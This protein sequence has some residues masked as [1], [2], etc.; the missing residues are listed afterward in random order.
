MTNQEP[1]PNL[2][3]NQPALRRSRGTE[4]IVVGGIFAAVTVTVLLLTGTVPGIVGAVVNAAAFVAMVV[5]RFVAPL[6]RPRL[7][8]LAILLG[9]IA[10]SSLVAILLAIAVT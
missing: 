7:W 3:R 6:Q 8:T 2:V 10:V 5:V 1:D 9:V 4:W